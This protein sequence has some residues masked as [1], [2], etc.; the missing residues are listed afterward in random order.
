METSLPVSCRYAASI[1]WTVIRAIK[2]A[3]E[4]ER[5]DRLTNPGKYRGHE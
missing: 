5:V 4:A 1:S 2:D 3:R